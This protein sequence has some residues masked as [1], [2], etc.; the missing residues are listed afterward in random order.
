MSLRG[1]GGGCSTE[2]GYISHSILKD[3][4]EASRERITVPVFLKGSGAVIHGSLNT[5]RNVLQMG[6][7]LRSF[8]R[9][10]LSEGFYQ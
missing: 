5:Q 4:I 6:L 2:H 3:T 1:G 10:K 8:R 9:W 7:E